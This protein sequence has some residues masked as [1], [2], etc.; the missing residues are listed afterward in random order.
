MEDGP[1]TIRGRHRFGGKA[2]MRLILGLVLVLP[3]CAAG[4]V[5]VTGH[6]LARAASG[7][8]TVRPPADPLA[9]GVRGDPTAA[10][11]PPFGRVTLDTA[12]GPTEAWD[13]PA[14]GTE[15]GRANN[16]PSPSPPLVVSHALRMAP[17]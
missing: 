4:Y 14:A 16:F 15:A 5:A 2:K 12:L 8:L 11:S 7:S 6:V 13:V 1:G 17:H 10:L 3:L 9:P